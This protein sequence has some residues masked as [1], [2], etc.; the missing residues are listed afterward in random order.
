M[1]PDAEPEV[2]RRVPADIEAVGLGICVG[3]AVRVSTSR[4]DRDSRFVARAVA[5]APAAARPW[6]R[7][8]RFFG[9]ADR[10]STVLGAPDGPC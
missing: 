5:L 10:V 8:S 9:I 6:D 3:I 7:G 1:D 2:V 4:R